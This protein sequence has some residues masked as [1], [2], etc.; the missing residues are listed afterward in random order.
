MEAS[1]GQL[2]SITGQSENDVVTMLKECGGDVDSATNRLLDSA[3]PFIPPD[4][5]LLPTDPLPRNFF[6]GNNART[7]D[8]STDDREHR[9]G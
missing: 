7:N 8:D 6:R 4:I 2:V 1:V 3:S 5:R 9:L